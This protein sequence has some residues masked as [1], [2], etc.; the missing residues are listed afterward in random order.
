MK[1]Y[2]IIAN[3]LIYKIAKR[4]FFISKTFSILFFFL[5]QLYALYSQN[6]PLTD[7]TKSDDKNSSYNK[8]ENLLKLDEEKSN[9]LFKENKISRERAE[10]FDAIS[11]NIQKA[12]L[13][14]KTGIDYKG[15]TSEL[16]YV[17]K[18]KKT[19]IDGI[20]KNKNDFQTLRN[21]TVTSIMLKELQTR[22]EIQLT[23]IK[24]NRT[25]L[26]EIQSVI[27]SLSIKKSLFT[28]PKDSLRK[29]LYYERYSQM[30]TDVDL[31]NKR[32]K[33]ALDSISK[34]QIIGSQFKYDLQ[35]DIIE[36]D[37]IRKNEFQN[38]LHSDGEIFKTNTGNTT[39]KEAFFYSVTKVVII[40]LFFITNHFNAII[41]MLL[42]ALCLIIYLFFLRSK[43][44]KEG[45]HKNV[46]FS[47]QIFIHPVSC[48]IL[49]S[50]T[51]F[52]FLFIFPPFAFTSI[53]WFISMVALTIVN[54]E[55]FCKKENFVWRIYVVLI[56][57]GLYDNNI[58]I[59]SVAEVFL[60]LFIASASTIFSIYNLKKSKE[61]LNPF[62]K[63]SLIVM[64]ICEI[65]SILFILFDEN[66]NLGK[67]LMI[68]GIITILMYYLF[69]NTYRLIVDI[70]KYSNFLKESN[71]GKPQELNEFET[72]YY[73]PIINVLF[74]AGWLISIVKNSYFFHAILDPIISF[75]NEPRT[76]GDINYSYQSI[77]VFFFIITTSV[78]IAKIVSFLTSSSSNSFNA[79]RKNRFGSW[80]LLIQIAIFSI[81]ISLAFIS[82]GIPVDR[83]TIIIS[84]LGVGI[85]FGLQTLV[86]NLVSGLIIAFE[87]PV[88]INDTIE[89]GGQTVTMKSIGIRSSVVATFD[90]A[91][92]IIPNGDLLSQHLTNWTL[93]NNKKRTDI[94]IGVAYGT[95]LE[96]AKT[97]LEE[98]LKNHSLVL[99]NPVPIIWFKDFNTSAIDIVIK[100][101]V[102]HINFANDV[103]SDLIIL[104]DKT[105]R[106]NNIEIPFPQQDI[107]IIKKEN[108][109]SEK[110]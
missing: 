14:L 108:K 81:G 64:I 1:F 89:I 5:F 77:I 50:F 26:S 6:H 30:N 49:I 110:E 11:K 70:L 72:I 63:Y 10:L 12:D 45:I 78:L 2:N 19:A 82:S 62:F 41:L 93:S 40:L 105:F 15:F 34:L 71:E 94:T 13:T 4:Q 57:S 44:I 28:L 99:E 107:H 39:F 21:I 17:I 18:L 92:V 35:S 51:I 98:I 76:I 37:N 79:N 31:L 32:F 38:L 7:S 24:K 103:K 9:T 104:I 88:N 102:S 43:F 29:S 83:L 20:I 85:G 53:I 87:K 27:D 42:A 22:V 60:I 25:E 65:G 96:E 69:T 52:N 101:W 109:E 80:I 36:T 86:N 100:F 48:G 90:G 59:H 66:Y 46:N 68:N 61:I 23:K 3:N 74:V 33:D 16:D 97:I 91:D 67:L 47:K 75:F 73:G 8:I 55:H 56:L 58:L 95:N 106:E 54:K 84:A